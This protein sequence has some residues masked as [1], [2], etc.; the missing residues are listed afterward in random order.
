M[1]VS[2]AR[3]RRRPGGAPATRSTPFAQ[4][5]DAVR[6]TTVQLAAPL[7]AEDCALQSMPDASPVKWHL[8]HTTWFFETFVLER[9]LRGYRPFEPRFRVLFNS[10]Y[11]AVGE[12][13]P[14]PERGMLSRPALDEIRAYRDA[15]RRPCSPRCTNAP[16]TI[17]ALAALLEL[18][19]HH[20]QQH[21]ELILTDVKHLLSRN[22]LQPAYRERW[23]LTSIAAPVALDRAS[24]AGCVAVGPHGR[25]LLL[26]QRAAAASGVPRSLRAGVAAGDERRV[27]GVHRRRR[28]HAAGAV[29]VA[30]LGH[31]AGAA[32]GRRR[33]TGS[34]ATAAG[35]RS[36][37]TA[38]A[39]ID[40]ATPMSHVS[41]FEADAYARWA[42]ARLPTEAEWE[43]AARRLRDR[44][45]LPGQRRAAPARP[46]R[47]P[48]DRR[49][50][51]ALRRRLGMDAQ[52][53]RALPR[54]RARRRRRRRVQR[55]V[56]VQP[57]RA[58][59][60]LV[61]DAARAHPRDVPQLLSARRALAVLR[62][63]PRARRALTAVPLRPRGRR[64]SRRA[65][66][67][68]S[69]PRVKPA[70]SSSAAISAGAYL[71]EFS[72]WMR[73][74]AAKLRTLPSSDTRCVETASRCISTRPACAS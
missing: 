60:R 6:A 48:A 69:A 66:P 1:T 4:R 72:V 14:R 10:Y 73:S 32:A 51:A 30:G 20:E 8:A 50:G 29:A 40:A 2:R 17:P 37:C 71:Y 57:V 43:A 64:R 12:R 36:R 27:P 31:G 61:R 41:Y 52:R 33:C 16:P 62:P 11:N 68:S 67:A 21:Q 59:R 56:H 22:P 38:A 49:R 24:P 18:G 58:A 34:S 45:E 74:P 26:R 55:Q 23:P 39:E 19:L 63:A 25:G 3:T 35:P 13:H 46:A 42:G 53:L 5:L 54:L 47:R 28:L 65:G 7:S 70:S 44:R 15:R 9:C